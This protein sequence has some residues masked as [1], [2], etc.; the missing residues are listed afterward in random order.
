MGS[1]RGLQRIEL[2]DVSDAVEYGV[3]DDQLGEV[4]GCRSG[5][6]EAA[7]EPGAKGDHDRAAAARTQFPGG[8]DDVGDTACPAHVHTPAS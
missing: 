7:A 6:G 1:K 3:P 4:R 2:H 8:N 5:D